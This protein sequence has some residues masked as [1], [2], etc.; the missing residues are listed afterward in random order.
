MPETRATGSST[1]CTCSMP[2]PR[3]RQ[4]RPC[5]EKIGCRC[6][7]PTFAGSMALSRPA[8]SSA[9]P[10]LLQIRAPGGRRQWRLLCP[11]LVQHRC[12]CRCCCCC[13]SRRRCCRRRCRRC[14]C[15][16]CRRHCCC[17]CCCR[18][19]H[20]VVPQPVPGGPEHPDRGPGP[21]ALQSGPSRWLC[22]GRKRC[23]CRSLLVRGQDVLLSALP[24]CCRGVL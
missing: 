16:C 11:G 6:C 12:C 17:C 4:H 18:P 1:R 8:S 20:S 15:C 21:R 9:E 13:R 2:A 5:A 14:C 7:G 23:K 10:L 24:T 22:W 19:G 3:G